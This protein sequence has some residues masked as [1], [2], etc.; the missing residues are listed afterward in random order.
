M[1]KKDTALLITGAID[2]ERN[3]V[4]FT[5]IT[6]TQMRLGQYIRAI[7]Y[8][9]RKYRSINRII[10]V[11]NTNFPYDYSALYSL[12]AH[13]GKTL[14]VLPFKG[15]RE[16]TAFHGKGFGEIECINYALENSKLLKASTGFV[17][18]T[19][20]VEVLNF[21][22]L[23]HS[24]YGTNSFYAIS[25]AAFPYVET[26]LYRVDKHFFQKNMED[27]GALVLDREKM[28]LERV[29]Y[30]KLYE[31]KERH[32]VGSFR[33]YRFLQGLSASTGNS[34]ATKLRHKISNSVFAALGKFDINRL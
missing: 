8:A 21:D 24:A 4:P 20:R 7:E 13:H 31:L 28:Y 32:S 18:L 12:A 9:I 11:E 33:A 27:A 10:F 25:T 14:E 15:N 2:V 6:N 3:H 1:R 30:K 34:Y 17:K 29:F 23:L 19:G 16:K 5:R 22:C 26:I